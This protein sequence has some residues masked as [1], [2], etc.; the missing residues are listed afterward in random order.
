MQQGRGS[1]LP[2]AS[3]RIYDDLR[4]RILSLEL[5]PGTS[6]SR[7]ELAKHYAVSQT[8]LRDALQRLEQDSLIKIYPQ[9]KTLV[10]HIDHDR[11]SQALFLRRAL[12][13]EVCLMLATT[14]QPFLLAQL[15]AVIEAQRSVSADTAKLRQFQELDEYFHFLMFDALGRSDLH[16]LMRS[17]TSDLDRVRR[18][19]THSSGQLDLILQGHVDVTDALESG[20]AAR[21]VAALRQHLE[22]P[23]DW[24]LTYQKRFPDY[25]AA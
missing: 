22:K 1:G 21:A 18:L 23:D 9:S 24:V 11:I 16:S 10:T 8:P 5:V 13:T 20:D 4:Q 19:Q 17:R 14:P 25:F 3:G 15:R 12:E 2:A 7:A 6:L